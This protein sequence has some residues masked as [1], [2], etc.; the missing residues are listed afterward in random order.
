MATILVIEDE[1]Q[2]RRRI[3]DILLYEGFEAIEAADG[4]RGIFLATLHRPD[5]ILCDIEMP[6][7]NG[8]EV[9]GELR[10]IPSTATT[11]VIFL[12][13]R[14]PQDS[15]AQNMMFAAD[16]YLAKPFTIQAL[17]TAIHASMKPHHVRHA[18]RALV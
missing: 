7:M 6:G 13:A 10:N 3:L 1:G 9:L 12:T 11:P 15:A 17:L 4:R 8:G 16:A 5:L 18:C 2:L 14:W